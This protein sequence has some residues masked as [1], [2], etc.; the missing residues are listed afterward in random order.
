MHYWRRLPG[1]TIWSIDLATNKGYFWIYS[2]VHGICWAFICLGSL[3]V[4]LP[5]LLGVKQL[6]RDASST[7]ASVEL[8]RLRD[9]IRHPSINGLLVI[10]WGA[11]VMTLDRAVLAAIWSIYMFVAWCPDDKDMAYQRSQ[12][13][14]KKYELN[15]Q[16]VRPTK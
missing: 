16:F 15:A 5:E 7:Q 14:I 6:F 1:V 13:S 4:D 12:L 9:H 2:I 3:Y 8:R 10:L 11:N